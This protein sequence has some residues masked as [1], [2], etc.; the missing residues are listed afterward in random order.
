MKIAFILP[1][2]V[3]KGPILVVKDLIEVLSNNVD[4]IDVFYFDEVCELELKCNCY[5]IS[6][7]SK[8]DFNKYDVVHSHMLRPDL[9]I[10]LNRNKNH[11]KVK[12]ISTLH[13]NIFDNLKADYNGF[14][15]YW[16]KKFWLR[17]L[18]NFDYVVFLTKTMKLLYSDNFS[19][20][21]T[22]LKVIYNGRSTSNFQ[23][24]SIDENDLYLINKIKSSFKVIGSHCLVSKRKGLDQVLR[25]LVNLPE[26]YFI[27]VGE[28]LEVENLKK[29]S[30]DLN[31]SDRCL[32][33]GYHR[34]AQKY[35]DFF[36]IYLMS[37]HSEGFPLALLEAGI[38]KIPVVC[39]DIQ[40][41]R[42]LFNEN[43]VVF[44]ELNSIKS[45]EIAIVYAFKN[46]LSLGINMASV[47]NE[48]YSIKCMVD[49]YLDL[50][51][52]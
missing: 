44:F 19:N 33:L 26:F 52:I 37:S 1:K 46:R 32:F 48:K 5:R 17:A 47:I 28:G 8:L 12:F 23:I 3:N 43:Q 45:L 7:F 2:L 11:S 38:R 27:H 42:E 34:N 29:L 30:N 22:K 51:R 14:V 9:F 25:A 50:Y 24:E 18:R 16:A 15:A 36:D 39:T 49:Q 21:N 40:I 13:Q 6:F 20:S 10:W 31:V 35:L 4:L 41:F